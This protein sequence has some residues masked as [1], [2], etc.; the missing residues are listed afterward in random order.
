MPLQPKNWIILDSVDSTNNYAMAL[1]QRGDK[2]RENP[3]F[4][5]Q[6]TGGKG[7][8]GKYWESE[9]GSNIILS[10]PLQMQWLPL[11]QQFRL[12]VAISLGAFD[13]ISKYI[14]KNVFIKWPND[15]FIDDNKAGGILIE[16]IIKGS[17]W[18]WA[19]AGIG[20]NI[21]QEN[22]ENYDL[23]ATSFKKI[24]G[25]NYDVLQ[26]AKELYELIEIRIEELK[27]GRFE[28]MLNEYNDHLFAKN[29]SVK[30]QKQNI[31]FETKIMGVSSSGQLL[32][33]DAIER[34][35]DFDEV[36]FKGFN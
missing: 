22:F 21:N 15:L 9:N 24:T 19:I 33:Q 6:Q 28:T 31:I 17:S 8:R 34:R 14:S 5:M 11:T 29:R 4:S 26:L 36:S 2:N 30:L 18:K 13:L 10:I 3:V 35:F 16:N 20:L 25:E 27:N 23:K 12:S 7:R 32:T 1:I